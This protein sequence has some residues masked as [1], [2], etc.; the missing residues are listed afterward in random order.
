MKELST[1][2]TEYEGYTSHQLAEIEAES[3]RAIVDHYY[4]D[5]MMYWKSDF[6]AYIT[7]LEHHAIEN[8][9]EI[10]NLRAKQM[11]R[12]GPEK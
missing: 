4:E 12:I 11:L 6:Q 9:N 10:N 2:K 8:R 3:K 1:L 7:N 5:L